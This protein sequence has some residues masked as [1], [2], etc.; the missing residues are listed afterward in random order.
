[1]LNDF[2]SDVA[3]Q[4]PTETFDCTTQTSPDFATVLQEVVDDQAT[5]ITK[6]YVL[7]VLQFHHSMIQKVTNWK[8]VTYNDFSFFLSFVESVMYLT[9][10]SI[11]EKSFLR[12]QEERILETG[13]AGATQYGCFWT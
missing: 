4:A 10:K 9:L 3:T 11:E 12:V 13:G 7:G 8:S 6:I 1:M 5:S 2:V